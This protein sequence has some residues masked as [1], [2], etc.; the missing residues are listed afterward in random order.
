MLRVLLN[1]C[2]AS[3]FT[4]V[5]IAKSASATS[6][7]FFIAE[8]PADTKTASGRRTGSPQSATSSGLPPPPPRP[9][10]KPY[11]GFGS[12]FANAV[13]LILDIVTRL[14]AVTKIA[15]KATVII[16]VSYCSFL[17]GNL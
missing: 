7:A 1:I 17:V 9:D 4:T 12:G 11:A 13:P 16:I 2:A 8:T 14:V 15:D 5:Q 3:S 6:A 10:P